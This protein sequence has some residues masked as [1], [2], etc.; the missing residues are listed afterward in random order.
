ME[1]FFSLFVNSPLVRTRKGPRVLYL[2]A[3]VFLC[4]FCPRDRLP[5]SEPKEYIFFEPQN[6]VFSCQS[7]PRESELRECVLYVVCNEQKRGYGREIFFF[8]Q[9][10]LFLFLF[11][12]FFFSSFFFFSKQTCKNKKNAH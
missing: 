8:G 6:A 11:L 10:G 2:G 1:I 9:M 12:L 7:H 4:L 3:G 5:V